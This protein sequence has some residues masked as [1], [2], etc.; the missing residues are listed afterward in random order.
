MEG[1]SMT[2]A[3]TPPAQPVEPTTQPD[4]A[5]A[6]FLADQFDQRQP[7]AHA[8]LPDYKIAD[9]VGG[10]EVV[11]LFKLPLA[12]DALAAAMTATQRAYGPHL[13]IDTTHPLAHTYMVIV[14][15]PKEPT[16]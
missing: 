10:G 4:P 7:V 15:P 8:L 12:V 3:P 13:V 6:E 1:R 9:P 11:C 16:S 5:T 14:N 2:D